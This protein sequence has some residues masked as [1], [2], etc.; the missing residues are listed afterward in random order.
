MVLGSEG[1]LGIIT[2]ATVQ[3]HRL[4]ERAHDPRLPVP[5][6]A[7]ALAAMRDIAASEAAPSVTRVSDAHE[8]AVLASR[9]KKGPTLVDK[10]Q[11]TALKTFLE[12]RRKGFDLEQMCLRS[13]ATRAREAHVARSASSS[14][15]IVSRARRPLHRRR[16]RASST[17]RRSST[18]PTSATSCS[19][20]ARSPTCRRP[21]RRG[22]RCRA[23]YDDVDRRRPAARSPS[24]ASAATSCATSRTATTRAR[25]C[26][27]RSRSGRRAERDGL[28]EYDARQVARSSRRSSTTAATLS[29]HHAVG[30]EH[31]R[32]ARA[33]HLGARASRCS[34]ALFD[35]IDP[36]ANLNPGKIVGPAARP[37]AADGD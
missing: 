22:A 9:R 2:E 23:L 24:S 25:A 33:G 5:D 10:L 27:S 7:A 4:P 6:W 30:T 14:G 12:R 35:G 31:A 13:S 28:D 17:T 32:V 1:R 36:G 15:K 21:R 20:A 16:A 18:R 26:T 37:V 29:H 8:T 34:R 11:S 3:V 19:T